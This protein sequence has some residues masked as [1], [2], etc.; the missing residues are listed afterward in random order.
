MSGRLMQAVPT[1]RG[2]MSQESREAPAH[3]S[4]VDA[5][6]PAARNAKQLYRTVSASSVGLEF[7]L[8][9]VIGALFGRWLDG[10]LGTTPWLLLVF[11]V[12]GFVAGLRGLLRGINRMD[13][14]AADDRREGRR[15]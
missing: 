7:G 1:R 3:R 13:R 5:A 6:A 4:P 11:I 8:A 12:L 10:E 9:V 15:G 2:E 14:D